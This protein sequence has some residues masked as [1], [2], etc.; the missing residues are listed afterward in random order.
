MEFHV[1]GVMC[2]GVSLSL[3][4]W[5]FFCC[6]IPLAS[7]STPSFHQSLALVNAD[8]QNLLMIML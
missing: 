2:F 1:I 4:L 5:L 6:V 8:R 7:R 3:N